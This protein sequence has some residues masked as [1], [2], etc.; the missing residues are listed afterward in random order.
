M[1][2]IRFIRTNP[3]QFAIELGE[4]IAALIVIVGIIFMVYILQP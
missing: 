4:A 2:L 3:K 1:K